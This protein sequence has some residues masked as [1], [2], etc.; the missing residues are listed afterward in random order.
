MRILV[1]ALLLSI[2]PGIA[3]AQ[4]STENDPKFSVQF[5][6]GPTMIDGGHSVAAGFGFA[7]I[8]Q[9]TLVATAQRDHLDFRQTPFS[10]FRGGTITTVSGEARYEPLPRSRV[11]PF[12]TAGMGWGESTPNVEGPFTS[13]VSNS[14]S[15][16][17][18]GGGLRIPINRQLSVIGE[19]RF[20][21]VAEKDD[22]TGIA[23][24]RIGVAW[25]F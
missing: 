11:S 15:T 13:R 8:P 9:L 10:A 23:P 4:T 17:F 25:R 14:A 1:A 16:A 6:A 7:P 3:S 24:L 19:A 20:M 18:A 12:V 2:V 22:I 5:T 21:L